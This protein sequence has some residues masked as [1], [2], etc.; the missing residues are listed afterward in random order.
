MLISKLK[1]GYKYRNLNIPFK[2]VCHMLKK[3]NKNKQTETINSSLAKVVEL[4]K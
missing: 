3:Q 2:R 4:K 1:Q